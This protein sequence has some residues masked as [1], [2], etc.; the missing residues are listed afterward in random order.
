VS[1]RHPLTFEDARGIVE[2]LDLG[3]VATSGHEDGTGFAVLAGRPEI[4]GDCL[5]VFV[6]RLTGD[7]YAEA[8]VTAQSRLGLMTSVEDLSARVLGC[9]DGPGH[10]D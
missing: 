1:D 7:T 4:V 5:V 6:D 3:P 2:A 8:T 10:P 9:P